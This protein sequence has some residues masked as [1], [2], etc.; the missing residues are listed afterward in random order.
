VAKRQLPTKRQDAG[1]VRPAV[2]KLADS[3]ARWNGL[4]P[5]PVQAVV[6]VE[7]IGDTTAVSSK[8]AQGSMQLMPATAQR[9]GVEDVFDA[10]SNLNG[11]ARCLRVML[12]RYAGDLSLTLAA[13]NAGEGA[14]DRAIIRGEGLPPYVEARAYVERVMSSYGRSISGSV[15][16]GSSLLTGAPKRPI[17]RETNS[18]SRVMFTNE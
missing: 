5:A 18:R 2:T 12:D 17:R 8:G 10:A 9:F 11:G 13:Y 6:H 1:A 7:S 14:V 15:N 16:S 3:S 4:D